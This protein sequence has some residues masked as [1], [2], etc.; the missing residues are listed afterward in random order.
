MSRLTR[1]ATGLALACVLAA[2]SS[3]S[4]APRPTVPVLVAHPSTAQQSVQAYL[5]AVTDLPAGWVVIV[6]RTSTVLMY[7]DS[8]PVTPTLNGSTK[9]TVSFRQ[10]GGLTGMSELLIYTQKP[11]AVFD[12]IQARLDGCSS[13]TDSYDGSTGHGTTRSMSLPPAGDQSAAWLATLTISGISGAF[14]FGLVIKGNYV[15]YLGFGGRGSLDIPT[16]EGFVKQAEAK[17]P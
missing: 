4:T 10:S 11:T 3:A 13:F 14:A 5:L 7:C 15:M 8:H 1:T 9:A 6:H 17:L 16:F 2:C 12:A